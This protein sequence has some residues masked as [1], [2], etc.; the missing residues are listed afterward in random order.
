MVIMVEISFNILYKTINE[1]HFL[2][3]FLIVISLSFIGFQNN[4]EKY[5][6]E[7]NFI[8]PFHLLMVEGIFGILLSIIYSFIENPIENI[9]DFYQKNNNINFIYLVICLSLFVILSGG[10]NGYKLLTIKLYSPMTKAIA[11]FFFNPILIIYYFFMGIDFKLEDKTNIPFFIINLV[12]S[13][14]IVFCG[15]VYSELF[16]IYHFN[17][18]R[19]TH[20]EVSS[21]AKLVDD[22]VADKSV[23]KSE[24]KS[25]DKSEYKSID[26]SKHQELSSM[27]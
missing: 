5:L 12:L 24:L 1:M 9:V 13:L 17:L 2:I 27:K 25:I 11:D 7:V 21:R 19:D 14:F 3:I 23:D 10:R 18:E 8:N 15:C 26:K 22:S 4:I 16:V 20:I 6:L